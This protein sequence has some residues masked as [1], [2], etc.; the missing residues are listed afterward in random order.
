MNQ[1]III[2]YLFD[3]L[4]IENDKVS[5]WER[6]ASIIGGFCG[7]YAIFLVSRHFTSL[8]TTVMIV[9]SMGASSVLLF[10][11]PHGK[12]SQPWPLLGGHFISAIV[13]V[14]IA[15]HVQD[16]YFAAAL[17]VSLAIG[18]MHYARCIHP[19][20]GATA[21]VA[22]I[23][24]SELHQ[25]G[26]QFV[27]TPVLLNALVL[28]IIAVS[29]NAFFPWRRYPASLKS[30]T[31]TPAENSPQEKEDIMNMST[32]NEGDLRYALKRMDLVLDITHE[33]LIRLY[34]LANRHAMGRTVEAE[35]VKLSH[36][37]SNGLYGKQWQIR[38]IIDESTNAVIYKNIEGPDAGKNAS[39]TK[40][41]FSRWAKFEVY[42]E[43]N[44]WL[45]IDKKPI[46]K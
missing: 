12:L 3:L 2:S 28:L 37:Y 30:K 41:E 42:Q 21:L 32:F 23:G 44:Q 7:I 27:I 31:M 35:D 29:V 33:D 13:G 25:L 26:Y 10:G 9:A 45:R 36:Y 11:V 5:H 4:G 18:A 38:Q 39:T 1:K 19:P 40:D 6:F 17:A 16:L 8:H 14:T 15:A 43:G 20:G 22:V 46:E 34:A 24:G